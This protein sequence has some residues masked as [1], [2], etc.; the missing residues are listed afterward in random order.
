MPLRLLAVEQIL[1]N[2]VN[3]KYF[4]QFCIREMSVENL[5][6]WLEV[7]DYRVIEAPEY[8]RFCARKIWQK[9][10][11]SGRCAGIEDTT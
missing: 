1:G 9:Y 6:F 2:S 5:L 3:L 7:A 8:R 10:I 11:K 4:K